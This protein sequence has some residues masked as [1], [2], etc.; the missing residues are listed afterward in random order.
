MKAFLTYFFKLQALILVFV[1]SSLTFTSSLI[2]QQE[3]FS[4]MSLEE[5]SRQMENPLSRLWSLT[6]QE[7]LYVKTGSQVDGSD[8]SSVL[9]FQPFMPFPVGV[10]KMLIIRPV[11]PLVTNPFT[12]YENGIAKQEHKSGF[13]DMQLITAFGPDQKTGTIWGIGATFVFPTAS[14]DI[15][16]QGKWQAGPTGMFVYMGKPW[17]L[18]IVLQHWTSFAGDETRPDVNKTDIQ[19][20]ARM[21]LP[22][23]WSIGMGPNIS[24]NWEAS[25]GNKLTFPIGLGI[26]KTLRW[27]GVPFK[28]RIEPQYSVIKPSDYGT[29]WNVRIQISPVINRPF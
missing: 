24:I 3:D 28:L 11:F 7:N 22:G 26:T 27:G 15:L 13:G 23:A 8:I 20:I 25:E 18:G 21:S 10:G 16:G 29:E 5:I 12:N 1:V 14:E 19:Y 2:A 17:T 6:L 4:K 9:F